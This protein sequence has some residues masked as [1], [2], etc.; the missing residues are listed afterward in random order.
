MRF[1]DEAGPVRWRRSSSPVDYPQALAFMEQRVAEI[2]SGEAEEMVWL[3]EHPPV[4]TAGTSARPEDLLEARFPV[5][6]VGRG[7][8]FTYHGPGQR[9]GYVMLDLGRRGRDLRRFVRMLESW[10]I[11]TLAEFGI[12]GERREGRVGIWVTLPGGGEGKIAALGVRVRRWVTYHGVSL[13]IDPDLS[14]FRGIVPCGLGQFPVTSMAALGVEASVDTV[15]AAL[16]RQFAAVFE[17]EI[18]DEPAVG[19]G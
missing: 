11:G 18:R 3:L 12:R 6:A 7:G 19:E 8:K 1:Q 9:V 4:Y 15:D 10:L 17:A 5:Y 13:N 14:H 16:R 2:R